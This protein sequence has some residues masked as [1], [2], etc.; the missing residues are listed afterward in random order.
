[1]Q[2]DA[3][4]GWEC[5]GFAVWVWGIFR[6]VMPRCNS[7]FSVH[8]R[9]EPTDKVGEEIAEAAKYYEQDHISDHTRRADGAARYVQIKVELA[10]KPFFFSGFFPLVRDNV[11]ATEIFRDEIVIQVFLQAAD[12][13]A[14]GIVDLVIL[15]QGHG[16]YRLFQLL[17][18]KGAQFVDLVRKVSRLVDTNRITVFFRQNGGC[19]NLARSAEKA[20]RRPIRAK[21]VVERFVRQSD[22][23]I[24]VIVVDILPD[25]RIVDGYQRTIRDIR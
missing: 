5:F 15:A 2:C 22:G 7:R 8:K 4:C 9:H 18:V 1:M 11:F 17:A 13:E 23:E 19:Q 10:S 21:H 6:L 16:N 20:S 24:R 25:F 14:V 12:L 3:K